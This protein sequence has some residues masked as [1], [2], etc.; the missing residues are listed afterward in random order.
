M[1]YLSGNLCLKVIYLCGLFEGENGS[2]SLLPGIPGNPCR[3]M[4]G[5]CGQ[6]SYMESDSKANLLILSPY[7]IST[8][9]QTYILHT[10]L[11]FDSKKRSSSANGAR[12]QR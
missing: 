5:F 11:E 3:D 8:N 6:K 12:T 1:L 4:R 2:A 7:L 10:G 9:L